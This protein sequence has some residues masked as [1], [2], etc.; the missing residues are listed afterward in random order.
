MMPKR[1][2]NPHDV[3]AMLERWRSGA[4]K[5]WEAVFRARMGIHERRYQSKASPLDAWTAILLARALSEPAPEWVADYLAACAMMFHNLT[6]TSSQGDS[7]KPEMV[8]RAT[9]MITKG[10]GTIFP[11]ADE[12][13]WLAMA[14]SMRDHLAIGDKQKYAKIYV[15]DEFGVSP[16]TALR[17]WKRLKTECPELC[18]TD[19]NFKK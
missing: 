1:K 19:W 10:A 17:A 13:D 8:A 4:G 16:S 9:G 2:P 3:D 18:G 12:F 14:L 5:N 6:I 15:A 11:G 7:I